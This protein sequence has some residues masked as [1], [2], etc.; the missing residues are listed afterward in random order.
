MVALIM[1]VVLR[2]VLMGKLAN[3]GF[4][5]RS[6]LKVAGITVITCSTDSMDCVLM[7]SLEYLIMLEGVATITEKK[8]HSYCR[9]E[10]TA[11]V[12]G[13]NKMIT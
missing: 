6:V 10:D 1:E 7:R 13:L 3:L 9:L 12:W 8:G 11:A 5:L 2:L 4:P